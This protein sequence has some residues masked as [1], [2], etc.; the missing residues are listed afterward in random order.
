M[1]WVGDP[2]AFAAS[3]RF[4]WLIASPS[5]F[6]SPKTPLIFAMSA[7]RQRRTLAQLSASSDAVAEASSGEDSVPM[8]AKESQP[9]PSP[10]PHDPLSQHVPL[11]AEETTSP[12]PSFALPV[13]VGV[14]SSSSGPPAGVLASAMLPFLPV[15]GVD[16][17]LVDISL[18]WLAVIVP[19]CLCYAYINRCYGASNGASRR[20]RV[21][22][23]E[24]SIGDSLPLLVRGAPLSDAVANSTGSTALLTARSPAGGSPFHAG[25]S[26][27][28]GSPP[29]Q[30]T[31]R[32]RENTPREIYGQPLP[33][34]IEIKPRPQSS[35]GRCLGSPAGTPRSSDHR[36]QLA[37]E[38]M[39]DG[40]DPDEEMEEPPSLPPVD[41]VFYILHAPGKKIPTP[42]PKWAKAWVR[43]AV[44]FGEYLSNYK[45]RTRDIY[46]LAEFESVFD[47]SEFRVH[48]PIELNPQLARA[49]NVT[50]TLFRLGASQLPH[51][52]QII[53]LPIK[54]LPR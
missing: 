48:V 21:A 5:A 44:V 30:P 6:V 39:P 1:V 35:C 26:C 24:T 8:L 50:Q 33:A 38:L 17:A 2:P 10:S 25:S 54:P 18:N 34:K 49:V 37:F 13:L 32:S 42:L 40:V 23:H 27:A 16:P 41:E 51:K 31:P 45:L 3:P 22:D 46:G 7:Q 4:M 9:F 29:G 28:K 47:V 43:N 12:P 11:P 53:S 52:Q 15:G 36:L 20:T 19:V 14:T